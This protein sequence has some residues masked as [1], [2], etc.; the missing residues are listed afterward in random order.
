M[1]MRNKIKLVAIFILYLL[2]G[3]SHS[4]KQGFWH[5][6]IYTLTFLKGVSVYDFEGSIWSVPDIT[7]DVNY[8]KNILEEDNFFSNFRLKFYMRDIRPYILFY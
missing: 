3:L 1:N 7:Y 2:I 8:F 4:E 5:D 6:E